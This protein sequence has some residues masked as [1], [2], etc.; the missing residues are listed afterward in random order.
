MMQSGERKWHI[1]SES[2]QVDRE[3]NDSGCLFEDL[4]PSALL[5]P[6]R[7]DAHPK[8]VSPYCASTNTPNE[9]SLADLTPDGSH[10]LA[11][12]EATG[13]DHQSCSFPLI[14]TNTA[15]EKP[16]I[17]WE[18]TLKHDRSLLLAQPVHYAF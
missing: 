17:L 5:F 12:E 4:Y 14:H 6:A 8:C 1:S 10:S 7:A 2:G 15:A 18:Q 13:C 11:A 16:S 9:L 3:K